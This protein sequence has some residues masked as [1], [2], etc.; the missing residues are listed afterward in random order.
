MKNVIICGNCGKENAFYALNC[1]SC[2]SFLR[3]KVPNIDL[4]ETIWQIFEL[5]IKTAEKIIHADHKNFVVSLL[6]MFCIKFSIN[7]AIIYN[8]FSGNSRGMSI[9]IIPNGLLL[10]GLPV[11]LLIIFV[12]LIIT[13]LNKRFG[14]QNRFRDNLAIYTYALI[15]QIL[16]FLFLTPIQF[17]MF[18]E[19]W[20]S[21]NPSPLIIKPAASVFLFIIEGLLFLW[22]TFLFITATFTQTR[23]RS[24]SIVAGSIIT[25]LFLILVVFLPKLFL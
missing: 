12:S 17:A 2:N 24:Y 5:P 21:F 25:T 18:G 15:P 20:F 10:G 1:S 6:I 19:Y 9:S 3:A 11:I 14:I 7:T 13:F 23:N 16:G 22:S 8:A 4:W